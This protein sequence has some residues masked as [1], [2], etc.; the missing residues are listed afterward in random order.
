MSGMRTSHYRLIRENLRL[1]A[2]RGRGR[3]FPFAKT[4]GEW[5]GMVEHG[6]RFFLVWRALGT[7]VVEPTNLS[8]I[9][10]RDS[11]HKEGGTP[12]QGV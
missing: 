8:D 1:H 11:D 6:S 3:Q 7:V 9:L 5:G 10:A 12:P 2:A 4:E